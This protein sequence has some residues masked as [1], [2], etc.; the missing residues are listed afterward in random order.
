VKWREPSY[1]GDRILAMSGA[2]EIGAVFPP[3][4]GGKWRWA[5]FLGR[6]PAPTNA[7]DEASAKAALMRQWTTFLDRAGLVERRAAE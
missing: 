2:V 1:A 6:T 4:G 3:V 5:F 7:R